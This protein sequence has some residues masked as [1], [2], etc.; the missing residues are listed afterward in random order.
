MLR[1]RETA[2]VFNVL[3]GVSGDKGLAHLCHFSASRGFSEPT[4]LDTSLSLA[5]PLWARPFFALSVEPA[6]AG[7][8][9]RA[10]RR[11]AGVLGVLSDSMEIDIGGSVIRLHGLGDIDGETGPLPVFV[12]GAGMD[13]T[14]WR[15]VLDRLGDAGRAA[16]AVDL[17]GH[18]DTPGPP[19]PSIPEMGGWMAGVAG[20]LAR[21][22]V[23][24]GHSMGAIGVLD[25]V[26]RNP[27]SVRGAALLGAAA[28]MS[29][30]PDLLSAARDDPAAAGAMIGR[31]AVAKESAALSPQ[32][33]EAVSA[34]LSGLLASDLAACDSYGGALE[35]ARS[36][37][38]PLLFVL[39]AEDRMTPP[40]KAE[41][42]IAAAA[43]AHEE[44][45][46]G[47]GHMMMLE[48]PNRTAALLKRF[49][50]EAS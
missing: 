45:L 39:G 1:H 29:V 8:Y 49:L 4:V 17:P 15:P 44:R 23:W 13:H 3:L 26:S 16:L 33:A 43:N 47:V 22:T 37:R 24:I 34:G 27:V 28:R 20:A 9:S 36:A 31:W 10:C 18:G 19:I 14:I 46:T 40:K 38:C 5:E 21:P 48:A 11:S 7:R 32:V 30:H 2:A 42:L 12:H 35:A 6:E 41:K 25:L 50:D